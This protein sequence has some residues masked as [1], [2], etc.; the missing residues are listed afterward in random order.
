MEISLTWTVAKRGSRSFQ[1]NASFLYLQ[2]FVF[3]CVF[4]TNKGKKQ[5]E[6]EKIVGKSEEKEH[7]FRFWV[8]C[9]KGFSFD[10]NNTNEM[11][12]EYIQRCYNRR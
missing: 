11:T 12:G 1:A 8:L 5:K 4:I 10:V 7:V 6:T 3:F 2:P 9:K